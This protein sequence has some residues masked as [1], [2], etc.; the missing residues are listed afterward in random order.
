MM[1]RLFRLYYYSFLAALFASF[2]STLGSNVTLDYVFFSLAIDVLIVLQ[3]VIHIYIGVQF[4]MAIL[5]SK[6]SFR[7]SFIVEIQHD[8]Y[9]NYFKCNFNKIVNPIEL[10][11]IRS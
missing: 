2:F 5:K 11:V 9:V 6:V 8:K 4:I 1:K 7:F 3:L 10:N